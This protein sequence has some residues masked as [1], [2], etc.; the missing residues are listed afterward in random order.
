MQVVSQRDKQ[1]NGAGQR[2][3][4]RQD[5]EESDDDPPLDEEPH[6]VKSVSEGEFPSVGGVLDFVVA[7]LTRWS[8]ISP[9]LANWR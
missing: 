6:K 7:R 5:P 8:T 1:Q 2:D 9:K 4:Q 3:D